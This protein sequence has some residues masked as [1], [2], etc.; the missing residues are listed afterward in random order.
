[1]AVIKPPSRCILA[2]FLLTT[3]ICS[4]NLYAFPVHIKVKIH[5]PSPPNPVKIAHEVENARNREVHESVAQFK[6]EER[7]IAIVAVHELHQNT[8]QVATEVKVTKEYA[9][10]MIVDA[11]EGHI[12]HAASDLSKVIT[13]ALAAASSPAAPLVKNLSDDAMGAIQA[14]LDAIQD[15]RDGRFGEAAKAL[16][17]GLED[18]G[19]I[20][21]AAGQPEIGEAIS[22]GG[23]EIKNQAG[24]LE[25]E[26]KALKTGGVNAAAH[27][28]VQDYIQ[29]TQAA[30]QLS[31]SAVDSAKAGKFAEATL[32]ATTA[33][34]LVSGVERTP[35]TADTDPAISSAKLALSAVKAGKFGDAGANA[36]DALVA[37]GKAL[38]ASGDRDSGQ[39]LVALGTQIHQYS[40]TVKESPTEIASMAL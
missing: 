37:A 23:T 21:S 29:P 5:P 24:T 33:V 12:G 32:Q 14:N 6:L 19:T 15:I 17:E 35:Q 11:R 18:A 39:Q 36:G 9:D 27:E 40:T 20:V 38:S 30:L 3:M 31:R 26:A 22:G 28:A 1:M 8:S 13:S 2:T 25:A 16:G 34:S 4:G 10:R 7:H